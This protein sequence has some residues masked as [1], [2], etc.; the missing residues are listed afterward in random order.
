MA[1][2]ALG[3]TARGVGVWGWRAGHRSGGDLPVRRGRP[4]GALTA[5][6]AMAQPALFSVYINTTAQSVMTPSQLAHRPPHVIV[7]RSELHAGLDCRAADVHPLLAVKLF[8][9]VEVAHHCAHVAHAHA[10][11]ALSAEWI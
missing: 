11:L 9:G 8:D 7:D 3:V 5:A 10:R 2:E 6:V 1:R 4:A